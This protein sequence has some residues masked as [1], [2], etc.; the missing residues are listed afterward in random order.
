MKKVLKI[1]LGIL[2]LASSGMVACSP[3]TYT[4][5]YQAPLG[6][7]PDYQL[8]WEHGCKSGYS[9]YGNSFYKT[10]Y[11]FTQDRTMLRNPIYYKAWTDALAYCRAYINRYLAG[12]SRK[13][14]GGW[15]IFSS[16]NFDVRGGGFDARDDRVTKQQGFSF[17]LWEGGS[18]PG[19]GSTGWGA[20]VHEDWLGRAPEDTPADWHF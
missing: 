8:G 15:G 5:P 19:S 7:S 2:I 1:C 3:P 17:P 4:I 6:A 14:G 10:F 12:D 18:T 20:N 13:A 9:A 16:R 11:K